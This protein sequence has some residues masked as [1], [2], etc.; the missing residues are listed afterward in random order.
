M[1]KF[2]AIILVIV[3][4]VSVAACGKDKKEDPAGKSPLEILT[5]VWEAYG[6]DEK[7][8]AAGGD[9]ANGVTDKPGK[10]DVEDIENLD[11]QL[12]F[13]QA[14][15]ALIEDAASL[16][17]MI[18][19]IFTA[20]AYY[21]TDPSEIELLTSDLQDNILSRQ[22]LD[23]IPD[24]VLIVSVGEHVVISVFG[25]EE[26]VDTFEEKLVSIYDDVKVYAEEDVK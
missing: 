8:N 1:K 17:H 23:A 25:Q 7:F 19:N 12:G 6:E 4:T 11:V 3:M 18:G 26:L 24:K 21:V 16:V 22:W 20:G 14:S 5:K 15:A 9:P 13:P 10:F 2:L